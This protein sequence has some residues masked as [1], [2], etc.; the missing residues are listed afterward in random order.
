MPPDRSDALVFFGATGDLAYQQIFPALQAL[1]LRGHL[2][3]PIV[4]VARPNR[5]PE[6][7]RARMRASLEDHGGVDPEAYA[8]LCAL[9]SYVP[10]DY[11]DPATFARLRDALGAAA[12]PAHYLAIPPALFGPVAEGL[13]RSGCADGAR[14]IVEKPFGRDLAS[15]RELSRTLHQFFDESAV[16]RIDHYLGKEP[17]QNLLYFRFAN[18]FLE[19]FWNR[20]HVASVHI[21]MAE[22]F[23]VRTRGRFYEDV[24]AIRDVVQNHLLQVMALLAME[25]P[26]SVAADDIQGARLQVFK[27]IRPLESS[28]VVRGQYRGYRKEAGVAPDSGVETFAALRLHVDNWRWAGVP[29]YIRTGKRLP[30]TR[31]EVVVTLNRPPQALFGLA[32]AAAAPNHVRFRLSPDVCIELGARAKL[33]GEGLV[34][35]PIS[36]VARSQEA[37]GLP[38]YERLLG[39]ALRG[40]NTLFAGASGVEAAWQI[41]EP[42]LGDATPVH[43]YEPGTWGPTE[44]EAVGGRWA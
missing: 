38:P 17:V 24:G 10:G 15:A 21:T 8:K 31:T 35:E 33:P 3:V 9:L 41:V 25:A 23:G 34:G 18:A 27:S 43:E 16:F 39:D 40:D 30:I 26:V 22:Q 5:S 44:A 20:H 11:T 14:V 1:V 29:F 42:V 7:L 13:A 19:P 4:G 32:D 6:E 12:R 2:D 36:L 37:E 28:E